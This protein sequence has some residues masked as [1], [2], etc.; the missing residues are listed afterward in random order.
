MK[1]W[2]LFPFERLYVNSPSNLS[3]GLYES[4]LC[5]KTLRRQPFNLLADYG[6]VLTW[7]EPV[8]CSYLCF[9]FMIFSTIYFPSHQSQLSFPIKLFAKKGK[10]DSQEHMATVVLFFLSFFI[11]S[12]H[13]E[14]NERF[15]AIRYDTIRLNEIDGYIHLTLQTL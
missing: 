3:K 1:G 7:L 6:R 15:W 8:D 11:V 13:K 4:H 10:L 14:A 12:Q 2:R 9:C 5:F